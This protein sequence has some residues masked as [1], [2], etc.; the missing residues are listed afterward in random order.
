[1]S[2]LDKRLHTLE[3]RY[4]NLAATLPRYK[5]LGKNV[6]Q[7]RELMAKTADEFLK[8]DWIRLQR[9]KEHAR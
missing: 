1:M 8:L 7:L 4:S 5:R 6:P 3:T 2:K 9:S